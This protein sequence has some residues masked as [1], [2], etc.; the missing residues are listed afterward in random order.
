[1]EPIRINVEDNFKH[2]QVA[3]LVDRPDFIDDIVRYSSKWLETSTVLP[4]EMF[5]I[6]FSTLIKQGKNRD[7]ILRDSKEAQLKSLKAKI[8]INQKKYNEANE[9]IKGLET[10]FRD[11]DNLD[12]KGDMGKILLDYQIPS[13][14]FKAVAR[15]VICNVIEDSDWAYYNLTLESAGL[16]AER[17]IPSRVTSEPRFEVVISP[18]I[19]K[20][21]WGNIYDQNINI[22]KDE[23]KNSQYGYKEYAKDTISNIKRDRKWYWANKNG[24]SYAKIWKEME[25]ETGLSDDYIAKA[26]QQY[27]KNLTN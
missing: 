18:Y 4:S 25:N 13:T 11:N 6:W 2:T 27:K 19:S 26:I 15:A 10:L 21:E 8:L 9:I 24:M 22:I 20:K 3:F 12:F 17:I 1:M 14:C 16:K 5:D 7:Q 23:Y